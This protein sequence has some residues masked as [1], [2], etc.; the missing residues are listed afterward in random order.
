MKSVHITRSMRPDVGAPEAGAVETAA[1]E[2]ILESAPLGPSG[3]LEE[4]ALTR[5]RGLPT[6]APTV[7]VVKR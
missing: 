6:Q 1:K 7:A 4:L 5:W 3:V 2:Q